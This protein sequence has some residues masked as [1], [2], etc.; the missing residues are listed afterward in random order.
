MP[1]LHIPDSIHYE[2]IR[3]GKCCRRGWPIGLTEGE[4]HRIRHYA[5]H[6]VEPS[7]AGREWVVEKRRLG[8]VA[9]AR[10]AL[11]E[12]GACVFLT[13][14]NLCLIH[15]RLGYRAKPVGGRLYPFAITQ[16]PDG[17]YVGVRFSCPAVAAKIGPP[18]TEYRKE[19]A[20]FCT[21]LFEQEPAPT[22]AT[23]PFGLR[24]RRMLWGDVL[25]VD[26]ALSNVLRM[27][28]LPPA[29]RLLLIE[30]LV[31]QLMKAD[32]RKV[33]GERI[34]DMFDALVPALAEELL[35]RGA[36]PATGIDRRLTTQFFGYL[37][38][39]VPADFL[40]SS[41][42]RRMAVRWGFFMQRAAFAMLSGELDWDELDEPLPVADA[43][44]A[45]PLPMSPDAAERLLEYLRAKFVSKRALG[46]PFG[47]YPYLLGV[48]LNLAFAAAAAW[49]AQAHAISRRADQVELQD[50]APALSHA[51]LPH[52][53]SAGAA[54][55]FARARQL[56]T[57]HGDSIARV[58][59]HLT[60]VRI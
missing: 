3:C 56:C 22:D 4:Y 8:R 20:A 35:A 9:Q 14:D 38:T 42:S 37:H 53:A 2:C 58:A 59:A 50:L 10:L 15:K 32:M 29:L 40:V 6:R 7:L 51:D 57:K 18:V 19:F 21:Q 45:E 25:R 31:E 36:E 39:Q 54:S 1:T 33:T 60:A 26:A 16:A 11:R 55:P 43:W 30:A 34:N 13:D 49:Y 17:F 44:R 12:D 48:R 52:F 5:W 41:W 28:D 47:T 46:H 24:S 27:E 23:V